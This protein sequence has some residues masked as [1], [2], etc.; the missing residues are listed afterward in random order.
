[1]N[2][3]F[4]NNNVKA[5]YNANLPASVRYD[6]NLNDK[7]K[8]LYAEI[9]ASINHLG[10]TDHDNSYFGKL[11][12]ISER[13]IS[14][15]ISA[16]VARRYIEI[17]IVNNNKRRI[18]LPS[19]AVSFIQPPSLKDDLEVF[20]KEDQEFMDKYIKT[21]CEKMNTK[22]Y[23]PHTK[24][25]LIYALMQKFSKEELE[26]AME[27]RIDFVTNSEWHQQK[28][29]KHHAVNIDLLIRDEDALLKALNMS[30]YI[31]DKNEERTN[32]VQGFK[33]D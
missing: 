7:T 25:K 11:F 18:R 12:N 14:G 17:E 27:A 29:N 23:R 21:W 10:Y 15:Y 13:T 16:L 5:S 30:N 3:K 4:I 33:F 2:I 28:E 19:Q 6:V 26:S 31:K 8:L 32:K 9:T 20:E 22:V 24:Y 1:M